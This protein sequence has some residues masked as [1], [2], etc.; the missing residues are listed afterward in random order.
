MALVATE[1]ALGTTTSWTSDKRLADRHDTITG[2]VFS[3]TAGT[4]H[5]QQGYTDSSG[6]DHWDVDTTYAVTASNG[7]GFSENIV[8]PNWRIQ[9]T[10]AGTQTVFRLYAQTRAAGDAT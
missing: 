10:Q 5:V 7:A 3:D 2:T 1:T 6:V 9:F 8:A 4:L